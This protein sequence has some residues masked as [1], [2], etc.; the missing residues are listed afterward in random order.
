[1]KRIA[2][3]LSVGVVAALVA[4]APLSA[5]YVFL[6]GGLTKPVSDYNDYAKT[7]WIATGG[8]GFDVGSKGLWIEAQGYF[9]NNNHSDVDGD[10]TQLLSGMGAIGYSF[11]PEA[12]VT[13]WVMAGAG[14]LSHKFKPATGTGGTDTSF[15]YEAGAGLG[16]K[17]GSKAHVWFGGQYMAGTGD[18]SG[19]KFLGIL[20]GI[21]FAVGGN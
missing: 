20:A 15:A 18:N 4:A 10:K 11:S 14:F 8:V 16:I 1:M 13:P 3:A 9:G 2:S 5:Q 6:G 21:T 7:G 19:T 12:K 17:A